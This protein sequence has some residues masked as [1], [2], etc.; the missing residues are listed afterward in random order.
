MEKM[1]ASVVISK[2]PEKFSAHTVLER[3]DHHLRLPILSSEVLSHS[4]SCSIDAVSPT[5][6]AFWSGIDPKKSAG[7]HR[8]TKYRSLGRTAVSKG[9]WVQDQLAIRRDIR[10]AQDIDGFDIG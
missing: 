3:S 9:N 1:I 2:I 5:Q 10:V 7:R 4:R 8:R 6:L